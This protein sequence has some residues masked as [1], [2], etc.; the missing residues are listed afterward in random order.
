[1]G[2]LGPPAAHNIISPV[3]CAGGA[4]ARFSKFVGWESPRSHWIFLNVCVHF[5]WRT[6]GW[7]AGFPS[8]HRAG[9][10]LGRPNP[11]VH[12]L[13]VVHGDFPLP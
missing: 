2:S 4:E 3:K 1:M 8:D 7:H 12:R 9:R 11:K 5:L 13:C 6:G 10:G